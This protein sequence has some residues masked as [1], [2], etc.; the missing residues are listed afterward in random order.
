MTLPNPLSE[1][2]KHIDIYIKS[3]IVKTK[4]KNYYICFIL[5]MYRRT[6]KQ[7]SI[8]ST[9]QNTVCNIKQNSIRN[10]KQNSIHST[11]QKE[12]DN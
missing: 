1:S 11:K 2:T 4:Q 12:K 10:K 7:N 9:K 5:C 6:K 3:R 8:S